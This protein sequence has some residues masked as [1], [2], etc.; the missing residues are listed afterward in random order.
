MRNE[1]DLSRLRPSRLSR[2]V[3]L[4][5]TL[6]VA[7][8]AAWVFA[9]ILLANYVAVTATVA[10]SPKPTQIHQEPASLASSAPVGPAAP[11]AAA[12]AANTTAVAATEDDSSPPA[13]GG[14]GT[15]ANVPWPSD[16]AATPARPAQPAA[17]VRTAALTQPAAASQP[18]QPSEP[19]SGDALQLA[20]VDPAPATAEPF[21]HVPLPRKR[22]SRLIAASLSIPLPRPRPSNIAGDPP[23]ADQSLFDLQVDRMR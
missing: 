5:S 11:A 22:P 12:P 6:G 7:L 21:D 14:F 8:I 19:A 20:A 3:V 10:A 15:R 23:P 17:P 2:V 18:A 4:V 16:A 13:P 1:I 9:P